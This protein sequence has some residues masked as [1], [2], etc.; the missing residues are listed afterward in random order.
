L[1]KAGSL[2]GQSFSVALLGKVFD[3]LLQRHT[4]GL[5]VSI[6]VLAELSAE[7][8]SHLT[9]ICQ[10]QQGPVSDQAFR[11]CVATILGEKQAKSI[12]SDDD[13]LAF[14]NKLKERKGTK[15]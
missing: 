1:D 10:N 15:Q 8:I 14:R 12:S 9:H 2:T 11:D 6:G 3:Q 5:D 4:Q 7:E 13:L